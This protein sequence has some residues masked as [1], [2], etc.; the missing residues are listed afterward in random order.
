[1]MTYYEIKKIWLRKG[2]RIAL[3]L[4]LAVL[5][6]I[7][8][9]I[10]GENGYVNEKGDEEI[11]FSAIAKVRALKKEWAGELTEAKIR[12]VLEENVRISNT[13]EARSKDFQQNDMAY[14]QKQG[15]LDIRDLCVYAYGGFN[16]YDYYLPDS[17]SPDVAVDFY[18]NRI[19]NL[20]EWLN[21]EGKDQ[22]SE[23]EKEYLISQ[24]ETLKTPLYYDYQAGWKSLFQYAPAVISI[25]TLILSFLCAGIFSGEFQQKS[26]AV[27][28]SSLY[29][30]DKAVAAKIK[31]GIMVVTIF[32]WGV[33]LMYTGL[34]LGILGADGAS[35]QIQASSEGWKSIYQITNWQEYLL[36][37][38]GG[39]LGCLFM[40]LLTMWVS[41]KTD[42]AVAAVI[43]PFVLLFLPSFLSGSSVVLLNKIL[44]I[45]PDQL[46]S[47]GQ[48]VEYFNLYEIGGKVVNA[49]VILLAVYPVLTC[50][51]IPVLYRTYRKK[52]VY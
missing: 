36:I 40:L 4:M 49:A 5:V 7:L 16:N 23:K 20:K 33:V 11:G 51:L 27:L 12:E 50:L 2:S 44:G 30:R 13:P 31:A 28:Y 47:M 41:A 6:L 9:F 10:I 48:V 24:Y 37:V 18:P 46:L 8:Y 26:S 17:L 39:Y 25:A 32:Y 45:L 3:G 1:M 19:K 52:Q 35:C 14:S 42:S 43:V 38:L 29:G 22:F 34:V 21:T 15:F